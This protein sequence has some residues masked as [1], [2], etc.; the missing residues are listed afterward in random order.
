VRS[1]VSEDTPSRPPSGEKPAQ[2]ANMPANA[3]MTQARAIDWDF[4]KN[5]DTK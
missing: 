3:S 4:M 2:A 5:L 1:L